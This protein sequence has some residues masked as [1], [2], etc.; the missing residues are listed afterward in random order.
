MN[1]HRKRVLLA[2]DDQDQRKLAGSVL[3]NTGDTDLVTNNTTHWSKTRVGNLI[4]WWCP[5]NGLQLN[6]LEAACMAEDAD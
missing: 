6:L 1:G 2:E 5:I 4:W 3:D